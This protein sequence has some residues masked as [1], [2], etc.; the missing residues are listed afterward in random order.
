MTPEAAGAEAAPPAERAPRPQWLTDRGRAVYGWTPPGQSTPCARES[1]LDEG[2]LSEVVELIAAGR[3]ERRSVVLPERLW[4][5]HWPSVQQVALALDER[6]GWEGCGWKIGAAAADIRRAEK[7]P[8]PSPGRVYRRGVATS[9]AVLDRELFINYRCCECEFAFELGADFPV[10]D[11]P[12]DE[13]D[14]RAGIAALFPALEIGD[15][16]F[17]DWYGAS[18]YFGSCLDNGGGAA[19]VEGE[20]VTEWSRLGGELASASIDVYLEGHYVKSG[21]G[22]AAMGH[23]V[24]SL[25]WLLNWL[26]EHG[27][28]AE[29]GEVVSTGTC[30][31]HLFA[32]PGDTVRADFGV[33]GVVEARFA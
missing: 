3:I 16:V 4:T 13:G 33:L 6:L 10:R 20:R 23:P 26:R 9:P 19:L 28:A 25:T 24:T 15:T 2:E 17:E 27:R 7:V 11:E 12:Y 21:T 29:A 1:A 8:G 32:S 31:G 5:R 22:A 30:T 18:G 14:A